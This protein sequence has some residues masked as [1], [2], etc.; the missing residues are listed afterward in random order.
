MSSLAPGMQV[1]H[2]AS[3]DSVLNADAV[4]FCPVS[5]LRDLLICGTYQLK[6]GDEGKRADEQ[7]RLGRLYALTVSS[8]HDEDP[9][10][11]DG[12]GDEMYGSR[13]FSDH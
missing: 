5:G 3:F 13:L 4:E 7:T 11:T 6:E 12:T 8:S 2:H 9:P 10:R 1:S